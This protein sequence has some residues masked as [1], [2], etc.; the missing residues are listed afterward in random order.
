MDP[1]MW[2]QVQCECIV[3][4]VPT[5]REECTYL[6]MCLIDNMCEGGIFGRL[7]SVLIGL[8]TKEVI[9]EDTYESV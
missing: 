3:V 5:C 9:R 7:G 4:S 8:I 6:F 2:D 1:H